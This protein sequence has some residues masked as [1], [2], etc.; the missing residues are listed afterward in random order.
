MATMVPGNIFE[1]IRSAN[2]INRL[3]IEARDRA[4][5]QNKHSV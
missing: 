5:F 4:L 3:D 1:Y 2:E